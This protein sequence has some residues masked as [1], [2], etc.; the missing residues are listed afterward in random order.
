MGVE[1][2]RRV[3]ELRSFGC[4]G[5]GLRFSVEARAGFEMYQDGDLWFSV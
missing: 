3:W 4:M 1:V 5:H 2:K